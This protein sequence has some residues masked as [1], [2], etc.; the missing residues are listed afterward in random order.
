MLKGSAR[1]K[2]SSVEIGGG[3]FSRTSSQ[4][5]FTSS[6]WLEA[7]C[8][9]TSSGTVPTSINLNFYLKNINGVLQFADSPPGNF[10][11]TARNVTLTPAQ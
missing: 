6:G 7:L 11:A 9:T 10:M 5:R 4:I 8:Q 2:N 1:R 3:F